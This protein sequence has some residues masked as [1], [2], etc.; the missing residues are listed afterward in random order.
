MKGPWT[1]PDGRRGEGHAKECGFEGCRKPRASRGLCAAHAVQLRKGQ[2]LRPLREYRRGGSKG[3]CEVPGCDR[4]VEC[5]WLC[6]GHYGQV[7]RGRTPGPIRKQGEGPADGR[8]TFPGCR[9]KHSARGYCVTHAHQ[10]RSGRP[11]KPILH[12]PQR[13][14]ADGLCT[15]PGCGRK[16]RSRGLCGAHAKM[17]GRGEALRP[18]RDT[19]TR[20]EQKEARRRLV[21][22]ALAARER[23]VPWAE[24]AARLGKSEGTLRQ[25][26]AVRSGTQSL[27]A[28]Q[29]GIEGKEEP[30]ARMGRAEA[31]ARAVERLAAGASVKRV[32]LETG[33]WKGTILEWAEE[34]GVYPYARSARGT[35]PEEVA[36]ARALRR[37]GMAVAKIAATLR[38]SVPLVSR[39]VAEESRERKRR[40]ESERERAKEEA[41]RLADRGASV[42]EIAAMLGK[43]TNTLKKWSVGRRVRAARRARR[44]A[45][46]EEAR[47]L[48]EAGASPG[49]IGRRLG[50]ARNTVYAWLGPGGGTRGRRGREGER[51]G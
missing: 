5:M 15:Y 17:R 29:A 23:G 24:V 10:L 14:P 35:D 36:M 40:K 12:T 7:R 3:T 44:Q 26:L 32:V 41:G 2:A 51:N 48:A 11:L 38:R 4:P 20:A 16:H 46:V 31:R 1:W 50:L 27:A 43:S 6:E 34:A 21:Q 30:A 47:R 39:W 33:W 25:W 28:W 42:E 49:E 22:E 19:G 13:G 45:R 8:C 37:S 18:L 9:R